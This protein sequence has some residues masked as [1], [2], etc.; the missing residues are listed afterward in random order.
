MCLFLPMR[1]HLDSRHLEL[2]WV[3]SKSKKKLS[4]VA[5]LASK[6]F[7]T[8]VWNHVVLQT[9]GLS[10]RIVA[11]PTRKRLL[12]WMGWN[13][14]L[15]VPALLFPPVLRRLRQSSSLLLLSPFTDDHCHLHCHRHYHHHY[16]D[17]HH[18][19]SLMMVIIDHYCHQHIIIIIITLNSLFSGKYNFTPCHLSG[20]GWIN[21]HRDPFSPGS[22]WRLS[23]SC[24]FNVD[25][26]VR[27]L[28]WGD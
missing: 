9:T 21:L 16:H 12:S 5:L 2:T 28:I 23:R 20:G 25:H 13:V 18:W 24:M 26:N 22:P 14:C 19:P 27:L 8:G 10:G 3:A 15:E 1:Y 7:L 4:W 17:Y 6:R 11:M